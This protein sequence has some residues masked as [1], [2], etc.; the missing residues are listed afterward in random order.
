MQDLLRIW[1]RINPPSSELR[2]GFLQTEMHDNIG[3]ST[4]TQ[5]T[6]YVCRMRITFKACYKILTVPLWN[7]NYGICLI[8]Y[9]LLVKYEATIKKKKKFHQQ[10]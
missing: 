5:M 8:G 9:F 6:N 3:L 2:S 7:S 1:N 10:S 4:I